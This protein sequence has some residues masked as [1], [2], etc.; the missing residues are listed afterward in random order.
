MLVY[1]TDTNAKR[2]IQIIDSDF[3][4]QVYSSFLAFIKPLQLLT[5]YL[6]PDVLNCFITVGCMLAGTAYHSPFAIPL[7]ITDTTS[8]TT[9]VAFL[10]T[11]VVP[12]NTQKMDT[13]YLIAFSIFVF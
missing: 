11:A 6:P 1:M 5:Y 10:I 12:M 13:K 7:M 9:I 8:P 2:P 3:F 4:L